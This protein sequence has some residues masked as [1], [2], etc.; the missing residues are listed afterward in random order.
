MQMIGPQRI[1]RY[2]DKVQRL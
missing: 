2:N 1:D